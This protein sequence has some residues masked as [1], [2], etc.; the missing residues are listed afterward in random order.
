MTEYV[1]NTASNEPGAVNVHAGTNLA[2]TLLQTLAELESRLSGPA[3]PLKLPQPPWELVLAYDAGGRAVSLGEIIDRFYESG[4]TRELAVFFDALQCYAPVVDKLDDSAIDAILRLNPT[5]AVDGYEHIYEA[6]CDAAYDAMQC[7]VTGGTL[8]SLAHERW[9][10]DHAVVVCGSERVE[11]DHASRPM[12]VD[13]IVE[14]KQVI[15]RGAV[16]RQ[17]FDA[18]RHTAFPSLS[19]GQDVPQQIMAFPAEYLGLAFERL[20]RLDN[21]VRRW[22]TSASAEPHPGNMI[23]RNESSLTMH[24]YGNERRFRSGSG[25]MQ[26]YEKH[27]WIDRGNRIHFILD[28]VGRS[29]EIG[30]IGPHLRTWTN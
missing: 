19:W 10:F 29:I 16:T 28:Y 22:R 30:Y 3:R 13:K 7:A 17:N 11:L 20:A 2:T 23:F 9:N 5:Q 21:T 8:V 18:A 25:E 12:H 14:R 4:T 1:F 6:I 15:A 24:N 26:T 27:V